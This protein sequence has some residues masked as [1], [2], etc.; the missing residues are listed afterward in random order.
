MKKNIIITGATSGIGFSSAVR[1]DEPQNNLILV[2]R[3]IEKLNILSKNIK[4]S[5]QILQ[6]DLTEVEKIKDLFN[7]FPYKITG[8]VHAA[9]TES[10]NPLK[11]VNYKKFDEIMRLH[12]YSFIEIVKCIDKN[13][14]KT[15]EYETSIVAL[16]SI[17]SDN[18]GIGQSMYSASKSALEA[19]GRV[20]TKELAPKRIRVN[21]IKPG[22]VNTAMT[23]RWMR[24]VGISGLPEL[25]KM[26]INGIASPE[27]IADLITFLLSERSKHI[28]GTQINIDGGGPSGRIF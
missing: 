21:T 20:L 9:G 6:I 18:G 15:D 3:S 2:G 13:K 22:L 1:L 23:G 7:N 10:V 5:H 11:L 8:F 26:Q 28:A 27:E 12:V 14:N 24:K 25:A 17:A 19:V 4:T 16:S